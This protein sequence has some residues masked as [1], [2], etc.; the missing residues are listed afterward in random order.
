MTAIYL[1]PPRQTPIMCETEVVVVGGGPAGFAAATAAARL[2]AR[3]LLVERY[4]CLGGLATGGLVLYMDSLA[5][6]TGARAIGGLPWEVLERCRALGGIAQDGP[7]ALHADSEVLKLVAD[8]VCLES[9]VELRLHS[10]AVAAIVRDNA[11]RGVIVESKEG[12]QAILCQV[13]IDASGDGDLAA[14][15]GASFDMQTQCIGLN[16]KVGGIDR[17]R[18][19]AYQQA[20]PQELRRR[21]A[22]LRT[23]GGHPLWP[24]TTPLSE[25]GVYWI[26]ILGLARRTD[27]PVPEAN[28]QQRPDDVV[29]QFAGKLSALSVSDL[30]YAEVTL[31][32]QLMLSLDYYRHHIPGFEHVMLLTYA[33]QLGVRDSRRIHGLHCLTRSEMEAG[34]EPADSIGRAGSGFC[35]AQYYEVPYG[36]LVPHSLDGLLVSGRCIS[37]DDYAQQA[38][39]LIPPAMMTGQAAGCAAALAIK[40]HLEPRALDVASLREQ[41]MIDGVIL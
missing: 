40:Q 6:K 27:Q 13:C 19:Q 33:S 10:W 21:I 31:R 35:P 37:A 11:V 12:R 41:L 17:A 38:V 32:S 8:T 7:L 16:M 34:L 3:T 29:T 30:S 18:F 4:G 5:D 39:R 24:N 23:M 14:L 22:E 36:C 28:G 25:A 9:G 2:G 20:N 1:E 15:A 26:N